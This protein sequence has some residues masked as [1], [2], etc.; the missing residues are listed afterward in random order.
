[1]N[2]CVRRIAATFEN[3]I[4]TKVRVFLDITTVTLH[5][6]GSVVD[7]AVA[8]VSLASRVPDGDYVLEYACCG[9][10]RGSIRVKYGVLVAAA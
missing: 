5:E 4:G 10:F 9:P 3:T 1:M 7:E 6:R 8:E 2:R